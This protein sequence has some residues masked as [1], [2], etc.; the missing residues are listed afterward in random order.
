[1]TTTTWSRKLTTQPEG[2]MKLRVSSM[3]ATFAWTSTPAIAPCGVV[4]KSRLSWNVAPTNTTRPRKG[5][6][7]AISARG[8]ASAATAF[9]GIVRKLFILPMKLMRRSSS[10]RIV[11]G[12]PRGSSPWPW[13]SGSARGPRPPPAG[14]LEA[15]DDLREVLARQGL[16]LADRVE[17]L[18]VD[19]DDDDV[20]VE[21]APP[22]AQEQ[23]ERLRLR[24]LEVTRGRRRRHDDARRHADGPELQ[25][26]PPVVPPPGAELP[27][28]APEPREREPREL[29]AGRVPR[30]ARPTVARPPR[31]ALCPR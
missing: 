29:E 16:E 20:G 11:S 1:M 3:W 26:A 15:G 23:V 17:R 4:K 22:Q 27:G 25:E 10:A 31:P 30:H 7:G 5:L 24:A 8:S 6:S 19:G 12:S 13:N 14:S 18:V 21:L 2:R 9:D 28:L